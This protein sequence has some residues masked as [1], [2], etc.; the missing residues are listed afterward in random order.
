MFVLCLKVALSGVY[1]VWI[2]FCNGVVAVNK[3]PVVGIFY[4]AWL[5]V[6]LKLYGSA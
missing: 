6:A 5:G 3:V 2:V 1:T 4:I